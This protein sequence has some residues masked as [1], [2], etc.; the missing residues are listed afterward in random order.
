MY[1]RARPILDDYL[2][3]EITRNNSRVPSAKTLMGLLFFVFS[4]YLINSG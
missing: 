4:L 3:T 2:R 1:A